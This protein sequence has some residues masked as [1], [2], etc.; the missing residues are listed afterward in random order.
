MAS[1]NLA[2]I[3]FSLKCKAI[4]TLFPYAVRREQGG[5]HDIFDTLMLA[6]RASASIFAWHPVR[7]NVTAVFDGSSPPSLNRVIALTLPYILLYHGRRCSEEIIIRWRA[8]V[9]T[10]P[11]SEE[12]GTSVAEELLHI[13]FYRP[14]LLPL[15][16]V[17]M[18]ALLKKRPALPP[19]DSIRP[20]KPHPAAARY[21]RGL[22][23]IEIF[24]SYLLLAWSEWEGV[25]G[26]DEI[27][28]LI[29]E[30]FGGIGMWCHRDD[31][32]K[33][34]D[35]VQRRLGSGLDHI[36]WYRDDIGEGDI[37]V[38]KEQ[39]GQLKSALVEMNTSSLT[40][41]PQILSSSFL[42]AY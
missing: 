8:A 32:I 5:Q 37:Q 14:D 9:A 31:L 22:G 35:D 23:D 34:L 30:D 13:L 26:V 15:I 20:R 25:D 21:V 11:Y 12:V 10:I 2:H 4:G 1:Q 39:Y 24:K 29:R 3:A 17:D 6:A 18:W 28:T 33:R 19:V 16:P 27:E 36:K 7:R 38:W 41:T 40:S 42:S